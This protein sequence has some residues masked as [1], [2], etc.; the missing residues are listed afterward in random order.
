[1]DFVDLVDWFSFDVA[2]AMAFGDNWGYMTQEQD[3]KGIIS[4]L[5]GGFQYGGIV[6]Q[7]PKWHPWLIGNAKLVRLLRK[8]INFPD[9]TYHVLDMV[10]KKL[11]EP[12]YDKQPCHSDTVLGWLQRE[13]KGDNLSLNDTEIVSQLFTFIAGSGTTAASLASLFYDLLKH[14]AIYEKVVQ[15]IDEHDREGMV[16]NFP[17]CSEVLEMPYLQLVIKE[18]LRISPASTLPLERIVPHGGFEVLGYYLP[19]GTIVSMCIPLLHRCKEVY[20]HDAESFRPERW[21]KNEAG[22]DRED[23]RLRRMERSFFA[24]GLGNRG[25]SGRALATIVMAKLVVS[26]LRVFHIKLTDPKPEWSFE[27]LKMYWHPQ[28]K[29]LNVIFKA[30][31][32]LSI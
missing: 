17:T 8:L 23:E 32:K 5:K 18:S 19:A 25:C 28:Q 20:G 16:S 15:E 2:S 1:V 11:R 12:Q 13:E 26:V 22:G 30:R 6:G 29:G 9:P 3:I 21:L 31:Q 14:P 27:K 10:E 4:G 24:F 7:M